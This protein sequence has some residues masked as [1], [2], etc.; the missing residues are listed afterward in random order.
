MAAISKDNKK[1]INLFLI[2]IKGYESLKFLVKNKLYK[3]INFVIVGRDKNISNDFSK[4][5]IEL[6]S[7][8]GLEYG[9]RDQKGLKIPFAEISIAISWKW[10]IELNNTLLVL[11]DS[12]LPKYR[13]HLPLVSQLID[14]QGEIGVTAILGNEKY[15]EGDIV[16]ISKSK[17]KYPIK[18]KDA[19]KIINEC[20][21]E[22]L[23]FLF[24]S[25]ER[26]IQFK[27]T[28]Q[29]H[30]KAT[31]SLWRDE[32]DY[33]IDW[34][35][36][37]QKIIRFVDSVGYPYKGAKTIFKGREITVEKIKALENVNITNR[38][39]GKIFK[40]YDGKPIIVCKDGLLLLEIAKD[41]ETN[42][43][44]FPITSLRQRFKNKT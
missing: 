14:G 15:D 10:I 24:D 35:W 2:G 6:C 20:Y 5:I 22:T 25:I 11:H 36:S 42:K 37:I 33:F 4:E 39:N 28:P 3:N 40:L 44:I 43:S 38:D 8:S 12:I 13:G 41:R 7:I 21:C 17:I 19:I 9:F 1:N 27:T 16:Y 34:N 18:I 30:S 23:K 29:D 32:D 31:Y 26:S